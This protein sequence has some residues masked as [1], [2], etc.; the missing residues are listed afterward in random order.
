MRKWIVR[1]NNPE[2]VNQLV[3]N[4]LSRLCAEVLCSRGIDTVKKAQE[5][6][7]ADDAE[8]LADPFTLKG[9][10]EAVDIISNA[11]DN[12]SSICVYG[13]YDCDGITSVVALYTYLEL[14]GANVT[15]YIND[16]S[17]GYGINCKAVEQLYNKGVQ[18]IITVDNGIS[19]VNEIQLAKSFGMQ[20]V[21]TD[22]HQPPEILP[23][24]DAIVNPHQP[25]CM[26]VFKDLCGCGV[27]LKLLAALEDGDYSSVVE[28]YSHLAAIATIGDIVPLRGE[29][30]AIVKTGLRYLKNTE[31]VGLKALFSKIKSSNPYN[32]INISYGIVPRIN[33]CGRIASADVAV[34]LLLCN[35]EQDAVLQADEIEKLNGKRK[36]IQDKIYE[37]IEKQINDNPL[38]LCDRVLVF[39]G[40]DWHHGII[41]IVASKLLDMFGKPVFI[42]SADGDEYR[43]SVRS[44]EGFSA[45]DALNACSDIFIKFGGHSGAGGFSLKKS[46]FDKFYS[47]LQNYA[48]KNY[49]VMPLNTTRCDKIL[50]ATDLTVKEIKSLEVL[51]P[52]GEGNPNP[53]FILSSAVVDE[54]VPLSNGDFTKLK[55]K[56]DNTSIESVSFDIKTDNCMYVKN[57]VVD[58]VVDVG[59]NSFRGQ[60]NPSTKFKDIRYTG[61]KQDKFFSAKDAYEKYCRGEGIDNALVKRVVPSRD[62]LGIIYKAMKKDFDSFDKVYFAVRSDSINYC[63]FRLAVDIFNELNLVEVDYFNSLVK[64]V[65]AHKK[66]DLSTSRILTELNT[67]NQT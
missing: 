48:K 11:V 42:M 40:E 5:L 52:F 31:N 29:N 62:D 45:F 56:Y 14:L 15:Y 18:L 7:D 39:R 41:G 34:K 63:K 10:R 32:S 17:E 27:V 55:L 1:K 6:F 30:R 37:E 61:I 60:E 49:N 26:S 2:N 4:G 58:M 20:V 57:D 12:F 8:N 3:A 13:D 65:P 25:G 50:T 23:V 66:V 22:H 46:D 33:A 16:R 67:F 21:V 36:A 54:V 43:G 53:K 24:A 47:I 19:A 35:D 38:M 51:E 9:M 59:I 44:V 28:E 64:L